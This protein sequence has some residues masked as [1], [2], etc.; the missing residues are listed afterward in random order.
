MFFGEFEY[1][2]DEK[3]RF[4]LPPGIRPSM[5]DGLILAP[6]TGEKCIYAYPLCEWKKL[7]E[8]LKSTTVAPSKMR[9]LNRAL[10]ALAFDVNLDAQGRLTLPAPLKS[11]A[12]V[13]IEVIVAGVNNYIEIWDKETWESEKKA[14]QEQAWQIIETLEGN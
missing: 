7:S 10:F 2:L 11:Y 3:G 5:K 13:N 4:P 8:S 9:R 12:G 14:S 1:K 6:G